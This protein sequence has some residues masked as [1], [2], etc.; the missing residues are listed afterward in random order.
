MKSLYEQLGETY[1]EGVDELLYPNLLPPEED[2]PTY[3]KYGRRRLTY[4][5][6]HH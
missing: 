3:G 6:E 1:H 4:L 5:R 2:S